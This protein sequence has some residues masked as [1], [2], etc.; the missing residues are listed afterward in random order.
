MCDT[1]D[2]TN[3]RTCNDCD[4][5]VTYGL[6]YRNRTC[7]SWAIFATSLAVTIVIADHTTATRNFCN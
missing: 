5:A 6:F 2:L 1:C 7:C 3:N 4:K